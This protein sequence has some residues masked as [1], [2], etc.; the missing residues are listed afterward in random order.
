[1]R[2]DDEEF[3]TLY[4]L[5]KLHEEEQA[6]FERLYFSDDRVFQRLLKVEESLINKY[7]DQDLPAQ[8]LEAFER[9]F[10]NSPERRIKVE[11]ARE[12]RKNRP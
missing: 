2:R 7:V 12:L 1:M 6:C 8:H 3:I 9:Y 11:R 4:L 5:G 10:L